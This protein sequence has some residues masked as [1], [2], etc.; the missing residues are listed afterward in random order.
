MVALV[1]VDRDAKLNFIGCIFVLLYSMKNRVQSF[2]TRLY[3]VPR[4]LI[5]CTLKRGMGVLFL[6]LSN[7]GSLMS[8]GTNSKYRVL[9]ISH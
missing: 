9:G 5:I 8:L 1:S 6:V 7:L 3:R 2:D 4:F